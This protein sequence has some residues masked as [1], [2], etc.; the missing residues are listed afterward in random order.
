MGSVHKS[1][2]RRL[3]TDYLQVEKNAS[4]HTVQAYLKDLEEY[5]YFMDTEGLLIEEADQHST[6][7]FLT[8]LY[9]KKLSRRSVSR[10]ISSL[11]S[12]FRFLE[13]EK[14]VSA[15]PFVALALPKQSKPVPGFLYEEEL[16]ALFEAND[17]TQPLGQRDQAIL[18]TLYGAGLR[19]S[20]IA[21]LKLT[22][23]DFYTFSMLVRGKG[24]KERFVPFGEYA[25]EALER[26]INEGR[27]E[28][29]EK[30]T[31]HT[32]VL[33]LNSRGG[34][35]TERGIRLL[36]KQMVDR[37]ALSV[38]VHPHKLRHTFA[39]HLLNEGA[40]LRSVQELL[41]H[42]NLS[43]TQIYT[44]VTKDHLRNVYMNSHPRA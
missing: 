10:K 7:L 15:N 1:E 38:H 35:L 4:P 32:D 27:T 22:D 13:R 14:L 2:M 11:R 40:D 20:E 34:A 12:F 9:E 30:A 5:F 26:Y 28:L 19:V 16:K 43:S 24:R 41:G 42:S 37:T 31:D 23:L 33:F 25:R 18:E 39:T 3:F 36:L 44:H 6:R 29:L 17:L 21:G 8:E